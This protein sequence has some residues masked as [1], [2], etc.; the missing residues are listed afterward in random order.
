MM[1]AYSRMRFAF[2]LSLYA[3]KNQYTVARQKEERLAMY[4]A[5][6]E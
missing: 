4:T 6:D 1:T 3:Y 5:L 2:A